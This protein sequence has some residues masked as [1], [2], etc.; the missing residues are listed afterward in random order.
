LEVLMGGDAVAALALLLAGATM[1]GCQ[2]S[3][4][5]ASSKA[6]KPGAAMPSS[7]V[8]RTRIGSGEIEDDFAVARAFLRT[9]DGLFEIGQRHD[10]IDGGDEF[11]AFR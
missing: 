9:G 4:V 3:C 2:P 11:A 7:F 6:C 1:T 5:T 10:L 8:R